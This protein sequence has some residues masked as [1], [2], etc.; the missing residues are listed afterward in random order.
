MPLDEDKYPTETGRRRFVKGVVGSAALASVGVGGAAAIS[1][2]TSPSGVGGG[3]TTFIGIENIDGPAPRG[4]PMIP[5]KIDSDGAL[6]GYWPDVKTKTEAGRKV[7]VAEGDVGGITFSSEWYQYCGVQNYAGL[8]PSADQDNYIRA[9]SSPPPGFGWQKEAKSGGDKLYVD[10]FS[11]YKTWGNGIGK[12]K[13]GKPAAAKWRSKGDAQTIPVQVIR[14][15]EIEKIANGNSDKNIDPK[16]QSFVSEAC[17]KGFIA[18]QDKCTHFCCVPGFKAY[19]GSEKFDAENKVYCPCH[20]SVYD[21]FSPV[22]KSFVALPRP[23][24]EGGN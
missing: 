7:K 10:D 13:L 21:P 15:E 12:S 20:Q 9:S 24:K 4:M 14:S 2:A 5:L 17:P 23:E 19:A 6:K 22:L 18:W 3:P 16:V 1:T 8:V 11:D